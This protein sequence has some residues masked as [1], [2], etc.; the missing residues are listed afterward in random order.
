M[1]SKLL[2]GEYENPL[3]FCDD[4]WLMFDNAWRYNSKSM[5]IYKMC[6]R[7]AK[8]FVE[9]I[10]PVLQSLEIRCGANYYYYKN[11]EPS[12]LNLSNDQYR[13]CFVC[14][15][16]IQSESIFVGDDPTQT[17]VE[18]SKNL[19]LSAI[20]DVPEPEIMIDC[21]V[22]TRRWHQVCAFHCDQIWPDAKTLPVTHLSSQL[23]SRVNKFLLD[24]NCHESRVT[25]RVL[26][27]GD[28][29][30]HASPKSKIYYSNQVAND[31]FPYRA[32]T[33]F[34]FQE[35]DGVEV[36]FFGMHVQ[37]YDEHCPAP[38]TRR[39]YISIFDTGDFWSI[40]I[41]A[42]I[43]EFDQQD[44]DSDH[45]IESEVSNKRK[46]ANADEKKNLKRMKTQEELAKSQMPPCTDLK[47]KIFSTMEKTKEAFFVICLHNPIA[48]SPPAVNDT[49]VPIECDLMDTRD[50]FLSF[51]CD[52][53]LEFSS[54]RR[55]KF[56]T[57]AFLS[58]IHASKTENPT[59]NCNNCRQQ[60]GVHYHCT[61]CEDFDL[62]E[63]CFNIEPKHEHKMECSV[64]CIVD[65]NQD[66]KCNSLNSI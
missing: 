66:D 15:N 42:T 56:S 41:E 63:K 49:D 8:L 9:S 43:K 32:K 39:V 19:F 28:K 40:T 64:S 46:C 7:L 45:P 65:V 37:E 55:A 34:A 5:K 13:F 52:R 6:Q 47:S 61:R 1:H 26:H 4:A 11:P 62:C 29:I 27:S 21:I 60:C 12:R 25:I 22:C 16:S 57:M 50:A 33:I 18:I 53:N 23:E 48:T 10:N 54:L 31:G 2:H 58:E 59:Y 24:K 51:S 36:A 44:E 20:N 38:N 30:C 35:I 3:Q 17:L 14:F